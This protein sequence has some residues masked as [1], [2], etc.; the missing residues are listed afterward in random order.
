[1]PVAQGD[2]SE[3]RAK[4]GI[5]PRERAYDFANEFNKNGSTVPLPADPA[6]CRDEIL[7]RARRAAPYI[8]KEFG[9]TDADD[10]ANHY[11][12]LG[13]MLGVHACD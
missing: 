7:R 6:L 4:F 1:M 10:C 5:L 11:A 12:L 3:H 2:M 9:L 8:Q 13:L